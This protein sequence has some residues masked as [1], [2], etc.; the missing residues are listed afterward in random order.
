MPYTTSSNIQKAVGGEEALK[1]IS[2]FSGAVVDVDAINQAIAMADTEIIN[3]CSGR[4]GFT[5]VNFSSS[6]EPIATTLAIGYLLSNVWGQIS[7]SRWKLGFE[8]AKKK[9]ESMTKSE[10]ALTTTTN[11]AVIVGSTAYAFGPLDD[12]P[13]DYGRDCS[14]GLLKNL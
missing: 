10:A 12:I 11:P 13:D 7:D 1:R 9:L 6:I 8:S 2:S 3:S 5:D 14:L 4:P